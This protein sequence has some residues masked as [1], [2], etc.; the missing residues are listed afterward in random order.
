M[1]EEVI[2]KLGEAKTQV[3]KLIALTEEYLHK[4]LAG[5]ENEE[6]ERKLLDL[7][8]DVI[9]PVLDEFADEIRGRKI[10]I[11]NRLGWFACCQT[12][13]GTSSATP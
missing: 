7:P 4:I 5:R 13:S 1:N 3:K 6:I 9:N 11:E 8:R 12:F 10:T 2:D